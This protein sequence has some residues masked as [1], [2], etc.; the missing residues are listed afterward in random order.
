MILQD[1]PIAA[2]TVAGRPTCITARG[3]RHEVLRI[4]GMWDCPGETRLYRLQISYGSWAAIAE[5]IT[6]PGSEGS[7]SWRLRRMWT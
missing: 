5:V 2:E 4:I 3:Q 1:E 6:R 7:P